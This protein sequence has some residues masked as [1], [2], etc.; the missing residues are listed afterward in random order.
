MDPVHP[1]NRNAQYLQYR[2]NCD[3]FLKGVIAMLVERPVLRHN[4]AH[5][6]KCSVATDATTNISMVCF[7]NTAL[8][9][10]MQARMVVIP[11][12]DGVCCLRI[13]LSVL[14]GL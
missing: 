5:P 10:E 7:I 1:G 4:S 9:R 11:A 3:T 8:G 14:V 6:W 13:V 12:C 2:P